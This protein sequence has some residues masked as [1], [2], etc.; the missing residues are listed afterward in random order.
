MTAE[1]SDLH[2]DLARKVLGQ[3]KRQGAKPGM[4]LSVPELAAGFG[5]SRTPMTGALGVLRQAGVLRPARPRGLELACDPGEVQID[6]LLPA[7]SLESLYARLMHDRATGRL[8]QEV[9]EAELIP[10]YATTRGA[11]RKVLMRFSTEGLAQR[12]AGHGWRFSDS[13]DDDQA[14]RESYEIRMIVECGALLSPRFA[15]DPERLQSLVTA[16]NR[17]LEM[18]RSEG[19]VEAELWF[20]VNAEF[21][22]TL[23]GFSRN[24][25]AVEIVR[26]QNN[27]RRMQEAAAYTVLTPERALQSCTEHLAI[28]DAVA[29]DDREWAAA[30][31]RRHLSAASQV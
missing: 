13:L 6:R 29:A 18:L 21:H 19:G 20:Q 28:L 10:R 24:R 31:L 2:L 4:R 17:I 26:Q 11:I 25:F 12:L 3:L 5:V 15:A 8:P 7:S 22:E 16:H 9:S 1:A 14:Y 30:L 27:L 23:A